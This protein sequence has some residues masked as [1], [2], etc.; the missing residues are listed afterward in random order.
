MA[1]LTIEEMLAA[2]EAEGV[3]NAGLKEMSVE[4][5]LFRLENP[6]APKAYVE[7]DPSIPY[8]NERPNVFGDVIS[9][10]T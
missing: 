1:G 6:M 9:R 4:E 2:L 3:P 5:M 7:G 8:A 10:M